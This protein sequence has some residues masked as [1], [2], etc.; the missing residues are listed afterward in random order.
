MSE[1][2]FDDFAFDM[3]P[4]PLPLDNKSDPTPPSQAEQKQDFDD[5]DL[6]PVNGL[7]A[8]DNVSI[9]IPTTTAVNS[10][11]EEVVSSSKHQKDVLTE[12]IAGDAEEQAEI[13]RLMSNRRALS[14]RLQNDPEFDK[15]YKKA[16]SEYFDRIN[17][18]QS[19]PDTS[20]PNDA[21]Y[22]QAQALVE[23]LHNK[24]A[25]SIKATP[26]DPTDPHGLSR[27]GEVLQDVPED[28]D[29]NSDSDSDE[30]LSKPVKKSKRSKHDSQPHKIVI[31]NVKTLNIYYNH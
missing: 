20:V 11:Q 3:E 19:T 12:M 25:G 14:Q 30:E 5:E 8:L 21:L 6:R 9:D 22:K 4:M 15:R 27:F 2:T 10:K 28:S 26:V 17:G 7:D 16:E 18:K 31:K 13:Q 29:S 23:R 1:N 24:T